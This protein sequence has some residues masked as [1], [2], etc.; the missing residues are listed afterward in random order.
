MLVRLAVQ[1]HV[2][3]QLQNRELHADSSDFGLI[4]INLNM[5]GIAFMASDN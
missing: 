3:S 4:P 5:F 2:D 1:A